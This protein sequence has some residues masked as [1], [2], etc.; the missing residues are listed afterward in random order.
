MH[1]MQPA[2]G[3]FGQGDIAAGHHVFGHGRHAGQPEN[4]RDQPFVHHAALGQFADFGVIEDRLIEHL[5]IF[6]RPPHQLGIVDRGAVVA[7][8]HGAGLHQLADLGQ[9]LPFA[10]LA[11][12][13]HDVDIAV[14]CTGRLMLDEFDRGLACRSADRYWECRR[15]R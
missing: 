14:V 15:S 9:F 11:D 4:Q 6:E 7:E 1:D 12:A 3:G 2:A 13:G 8:G 10:V 5:A